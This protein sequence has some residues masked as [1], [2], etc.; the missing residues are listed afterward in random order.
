[1]STLWLIHQ[2][3]ADS[4]C[5]YAALVLAH[6]ECLFPGLCRNPPVTRP[7]P[8]IRLFISLMTLLQSWLRRDAKQV[9]TG[10]R[11]HI[12]PAHLSFFR[13]A[14]RRTAPAGPD[15]AAAAASAPRSRATVRNSLRLTSIS[16]FDA[17]RRKLMSWQN[18]SAS[19]GAQKTCG[20]AGASW[21]FQW[22]VAA[23]PRVPRGY[24]DGRSRRRRGC[25][26]DIPMAGRGA[27]AGASWPFRWQRR[28]Q[29]GY[30]EDAAIDGAHEDA[31]FVEVILR[32]ELL[33]VRAGEAVEPLRDEDGR[34]DVEKQ[35]ALHLRA[36]PNSSPRNLHVAAAAE[37][38]RADTVR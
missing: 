28:P 1:M 5:T 36:R 3:T 29:S 23:P 37:S 34:R 19:S 38:T 18:A 2:R 31:A 26:V 7:P 11:G 27:A 14:R 12:A 22:R 20:C 32:R 17:S 33:P 6:P 4:S 10:G 25:L 24:S 8:V 21:A 35:P 30:S 16:I 15:G 9:K 13:F